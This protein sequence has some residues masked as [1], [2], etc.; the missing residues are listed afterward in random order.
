LD[1]DKAVKYLKA[2]K[3]TH[4]EQ[5]EWYAANDFEAWIGNRDVQQMLDAFGDTKF[6]AKTSKEYQQIINWLE[7]VRYK[8][9]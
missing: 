4:D 2:C 5:V 6:H 3:R 1:I 8:L 9:E 7:S